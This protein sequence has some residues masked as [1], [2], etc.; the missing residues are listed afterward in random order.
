MAREADGAD[1]QAVP[2]DA[3]AAPEREPGREWRALDWAVAAAGLA[4]AAFALAHL[5]AAWLAR[6][7][8]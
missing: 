2:D 5:A 8:L 6:R 4:T 3:S 1:A 7:R